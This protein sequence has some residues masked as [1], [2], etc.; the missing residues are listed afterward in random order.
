MKFIP[1]LWAESADQ[2]HVNNRS[3]LVSAP[4]ANYY[5]GC[6]TSNVWRR[7]MSRSRESRPHGSRKQQTKITFAACAR[8]LNRFK[9]LSWGTGIRSVSSLSLDLNPW[10]EDSAKKISRKR[11]G[12]V[13]LDHFVVFTSCMLHLE[14]SR[15][16]T[17][18]H[19]REFFLWPQMQWTG[20]STRCLRVCCDIS[21]HF[22]LGVSP[23]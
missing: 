14:V 17:A 3:R 2:K 7:N 15:P 13:L 5:N 21:A 20:Y 1:K 6:Q 22:P 23:Q 19:G 4:G 11:L 9:K 8:T 16:K 12:N 10:G 18:K